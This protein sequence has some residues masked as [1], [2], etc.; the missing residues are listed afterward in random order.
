MQLGEWYIIDN[1]KNLHRIIGLHM[2]ECL[3]LPPELSMQGESSEMT[4]PIDSNSNND[5]QAF[6][7]FNS[8]KNDQEVILPIF[9]EVYG[10]ATGDSNFPMGKNFTYI[11]DC[12]VLYQVRW[13]YP[14][15]IYRL[16]ET[17]KSTQLV[18]KAASKRDDKIP[19]GLRGTLQ[20]L[21][22]NILDLVIIQLPKI[23]SY[24]IC[25]LCGSSIPIKNLL[26]H[27]SLNCS[28]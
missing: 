3:L 26:K 21:M 8:M 20:G 5:E 4:Q 6:K 22:A 12:E 16:D 19:G 1:R 13:F 15:E 28:P 2:P 23:I 24:D 11:S 10:S 9:E 25:L 17:M 18:H 27:D 7:A 14:L